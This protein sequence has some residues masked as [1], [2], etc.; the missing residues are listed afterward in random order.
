MG[1]FLE[2][3]TCAFVSVEIKSWMGGKFAVP[4]VHLCVLCTF[5]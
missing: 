3:L 4:S 5:V 1:G 2:G